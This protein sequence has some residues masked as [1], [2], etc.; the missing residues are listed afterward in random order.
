MLL[1][2][3]RGD[4]FIDIP[5]HAWFPKVWHGSLKVRFRFIRCCSVELFGPF[6]N[7]LTRSYLK[8]KNI[9][10]VCKNFLQC[11]VIKI[12]KPF[13]PLLIEVNL[14]LR[15][16]FPTFPLELPNNFSKVSIYLSPASSIFHLP[17][18]TLSS[19]RPGNPPMHR[20]PRHVILS[21]STLTH[22]SSNI[23]YKL[24]STRQVVTIHK[25]VPPSLQITKLTNLHN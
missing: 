12:C 5:R 7:S 2:S 6:V 16:K 4:F 23:S 10:L 9:F 22:H 25:L 18:P 1:V 3:S 11:G 19:K 13:P 8:K 15:N 21:T 17:P 24:A 20:T 14:I